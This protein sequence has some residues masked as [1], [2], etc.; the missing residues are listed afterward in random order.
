MNSL[1]Y[2]PLNFD[3]NTVGPKLRCVTGSLG[4]LRIFER[5]WDFGATCKL[6][7]VEFPAE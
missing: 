4:Q 5:T 6:L 1:K 7:T 3:V 2:L